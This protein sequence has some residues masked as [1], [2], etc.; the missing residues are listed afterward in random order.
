MGLA[1]MISELF[2]DIL[3]E[4]DGGSKRIKEP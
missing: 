3:D 4:T 1:V 2:Q